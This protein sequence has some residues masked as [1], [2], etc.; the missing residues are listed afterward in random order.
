MLKFVL[1]FIESTFMVHFVLGLFLS[2]DVS[3]TIHDVLVFI[4][5]NLLKVETMELGVFQTAV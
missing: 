4:V 1:F 2:A 5:L 3:S